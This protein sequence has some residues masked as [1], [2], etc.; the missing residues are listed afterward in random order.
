MAII[1]QIVTHC[2]WIKGSL[3][4]LSI[5]TAPVEQQIRTKTSK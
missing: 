5:G 3:E 1:Q 4:S 2:P